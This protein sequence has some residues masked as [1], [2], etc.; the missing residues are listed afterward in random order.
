MDS[1]KM[2]R[3]QAVA[4]QSW[5]RTIDDRLGIS[6]EEKQRKEREPSKPLPAVEHL[7]ADKN[8]HLFA[9]S[10]EQQL[11]PD[12]EYG[13]DLEVP[14]YLYNRGEL[15][16][17]MV[18]RGTLTDEERYRIN[19]HIV[20]TI[21]MLKKLP[22]PKHLAEVPDIAGSH[23]EKINGN[24]YPR[25]LSGEEMSLPAKMMVI[26]DIFEALT[27]SD[28]PY[29]KAKTLNEAIKI[30]SFMEKDQHIDPQLFRLF[31]TSGAYLEYAMEFLHPEQIDDVV[32]S[33][34]IGD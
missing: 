26:A 3:L 15:H 14:D 32:I 24:G 20:Q 21:I 31:L 25:K 29:K 7:L 27:A 17:L 28:R 2:K 16:N 22:Y 4:Q 30:M 1:S 33:H 5:K 13:F 11:S 9:R 10:E 6:W 34:Y 23:H 18:E 8:E 19:D 12:N